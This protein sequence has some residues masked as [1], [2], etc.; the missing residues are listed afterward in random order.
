MKGGTLPIKGMILG[1]IWKRLNELE[2][3]KWNFKGSYI[4][5]RAHRLLE[6]L[7]KASKEDEVLNYDPRYEFLFRK[8][9]YYHPNKWD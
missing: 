8:S 9:I 7:C 3:L 4:H 5:K 1:A 2:I 6:K